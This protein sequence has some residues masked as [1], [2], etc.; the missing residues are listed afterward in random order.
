MFLARYDNNGET[1]FYIYYKNNG[2]Y[3]QFFEDTFSPMLENIEVLDLKVK[4][5]TY[6]ERKDYL[7]QL[8][9]DYQT[10]FASLC[11]SYGELAEIYSFFEKNG[12]R[13][14][15]LKEFK[16]NAIC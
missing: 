4:G 13:Y 14:G 5:N 12:K 7:E 8:A 15:L 3:K 11:W 6:A 10:R 2:G 16:E 9:I 1:E